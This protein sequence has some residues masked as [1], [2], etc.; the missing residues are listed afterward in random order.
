V[1]PRST[2]DEQAARSELQRRPALR[3][4]LLGTDAFSSGV[5]PLAHLRTEVAILR[6][7]GWRHMQV[8]SK[9]QPFSRQQLSEGSRLHTGHSAA[10]GGSSQ[11]GNPFMRGSSVSYTSEAMTGKPCSTTW[12]R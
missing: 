9:A 4:S 12:T 3:T 11:C 8:I 6:A 10:Y 7:Q 2:R 1:H 5:A